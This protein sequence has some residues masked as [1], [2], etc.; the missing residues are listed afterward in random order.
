VKPTTTKTAGYVFCALLALCSSAAAQQ[1]KKI[2]RIGY[3]AGFSTITNRV[4]AFRQGL[5]Q[6]GYTEGKD[7][8]Y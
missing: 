8:G 4:G 7:I 2:P 1:Q 3:L 6:L 5:R